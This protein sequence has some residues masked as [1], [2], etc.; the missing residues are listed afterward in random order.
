MQALQLLRET[1]FVGG[2]VAADADLPRIERRA[3]AARGARRHRHQRD[4]P[5]AARVLLD[6]ARQETGAVRQ[7]A[8]DKL[9]RLAKRGGEEV[10]T[11]L[12]QARDV[13]DGEPREALDRMLTPAARA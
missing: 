1:D 9:A 7:A 13:E 8:E 11:L 2:L 10:A 5:G 3:R 6:V 4:P 12:G